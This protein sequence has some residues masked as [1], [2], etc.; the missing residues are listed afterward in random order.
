MIVL[1]PSIVGRETIDDLDFEHG[2][3]Y[4]YAMNGVGLNPVNL[5]SLKSSFDSNA[6]NYKLN[7]K[8]GVIELLITD[9]WIKIDRDK[10]IPEKMHI[11]AVFGYRPLGLDFND[12]HCFRLHSNR[13]FSEKSGRNLAIRQGGYAQKDNALTLDNLAIEFNSMASL[14]RM[15]VQRPIFAG[16]FKMPEEG[17]L[18]NPRH[19]SLKHNVLVS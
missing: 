4:T 2:N 8:E 12:F 9:G 3:C 19:V 1:K 10:I 16:F 6:D 13:I 11:I 17:L 14:S 15:S 7:S 18:V 5:G